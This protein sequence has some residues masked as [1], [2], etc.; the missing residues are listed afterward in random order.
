MVATGTLR[1]DIYLHVSPGRNTDRFYLLPENDKVQLLV[2]ASVPKAAPGRAR[3][4]GKASRL[5]RPR[6]HPPTPQPAK[7]P[8]AQLAEVGIGRPTLRLAEQAG[9]SPKFQW[10]TGG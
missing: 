3:S 6:K 5:R 4:T 10:R 2:R 8:D 1:D 9:R 7:A